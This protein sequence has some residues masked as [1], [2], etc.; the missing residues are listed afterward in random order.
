MKCGKEYSLL[1]LHEFNFLVETDL[2][3]VAIRHEAR[4]LAW[5]AWANGRMLAEEEQTLRDFE[6]KEG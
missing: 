2:D 4:A 6:L 3:F 1:S 5:A